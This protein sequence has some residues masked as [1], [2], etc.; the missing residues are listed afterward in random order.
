MKRENGDDGEASAGRE[1]TI[2]AWAARQRLDAAD[3]TGG[4]CPY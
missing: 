4:H 1:V 2:F 3:A